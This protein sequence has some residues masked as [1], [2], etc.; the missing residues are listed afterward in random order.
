VETERPSER[1]VEQRLRNRVMESLEALSQGDDGVRAVGVGEYV[2]EFFDQISDDARWDWRTWST[3]TPDEVTA[4]DA[5]LRL[6]VAACDA[7]P[8][9]DDVDGF[10]ASGWPEQIARPRALRS[11]S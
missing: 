4:L 11:T 5:V 10:I 3:F 7:T 2:E 1:L 8:G 9:V 6:V